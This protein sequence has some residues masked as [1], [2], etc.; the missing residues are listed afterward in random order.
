M[1]LRINARSLSVEKHRGYKLRD[2]GLDERKL[3]N[4]LFRSLDR[5]FADDELILLMQSRRGPEEPDLMA[6]DK[7]GSLY[8]FE[9]KAWESVSENLLQVLRYGQIYGASKYNELD[10]MYRRLG[11]A[12]QTLSAA[13][14]EKFGTELSEKDFNKSQVFVVVTNGLDHQTRAAIK[15]WCSCGLD[16]RPWVYRV[17]KSATDGDCSLEINAF[18]TYD[19]PYEDLA[20][21]YFILNTNV[22]N[23]PADHEDMLTNK[24]AAAYFSPWKE[25]IARLGKG[26]LVFLY[27]SGVGVVALGE[28]DGQL[29]KADYHSNP[30]HPEEEYYRK[31]NNF[32]TI[33]P[34]LTAAEIK[35]ITGT[36]YV[37][38]STLFGLDEDSG[39]KIRRYVDDRNAATTSK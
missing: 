25:K 26:D 18:R 16:I 4:I 22:R 17:Y 37:F 9:L 15:Y 7:D 38:M 32:R 10:A 12:R 13:H 1:L 27:Q 39:K 5:L 20:E 11:G 31:L 28:A 34:P 30:E 2:V 14:K 24:K 35:K 3:Q 29:R 33:D 8:I 19:N 36:N 21:G 23:D 6:I